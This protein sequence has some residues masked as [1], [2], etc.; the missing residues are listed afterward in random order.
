MVGANGVNRGRK[1][2]EKL[3]CKKRRFL[4]TENNEDRRQIA[5]NQEDKKCL[6]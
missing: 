6:Q 4:Y 1:R 5:Q 2:A 3:F